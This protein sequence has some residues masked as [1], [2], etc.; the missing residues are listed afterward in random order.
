MNGTQ[1]SFC[2]W[3]LRV[4]SFFLTHSPFWEDLKWYTTIIFTAIIKLQQ[5]QIGI[6]LLRLY[7]KAVNIMVRY[8]NA[9]KQKLNLNWYLI[10]SFSIVDL[11]IEGF[12]HS[13]FLKFSFIQQTMFFKNKLYK[14]PN[15]VVI[16]IRACRNILEIDNHLNDTQHHEAPQNDN[17]K[18]KS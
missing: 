5:N 15:Y 11:T 1:D 18:L 8:W 3:T 4:L 13:F 10:N 16:S 2:V 7:L 6:Q 17:L 12:Q 9:N 14:I